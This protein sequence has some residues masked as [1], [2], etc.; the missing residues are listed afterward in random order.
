MLENLFAQL[1]ALSPA[2]KGALLVLAI[3]QC[4]LQIFCVIDLVRRPAVTG[5]NKWIWA[6]LI[7][8]AGLLGCL[9]YFA[10]GRS[11]ASLDQDDGAGGDTATQRAIDKLYGDKR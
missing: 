4:I 7:V 11:H 8:A 3:V 10:I 6:A 9:L 1:A 5:G 2:V